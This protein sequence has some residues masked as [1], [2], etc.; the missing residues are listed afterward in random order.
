MTKTF[1]G[2]KWT[3][4]N[5][6]LNPESCIHG[7]RVLLQV[8]AQCVPWPSL[9]SMRLTTA[10]GPAPSATTSASTR[11]R[12][13]SS[14]A[15]WW[16]ARSASAPGPGSSSWGRGTRVSWCAEWRQPGPGPIS[17]GASRPLR[18]SGGS[19]TPVERW[20]QKERRIFQLNRGSNNT[21]ELQLI[22]PILILCWMD[23]ASLYEYSNR[24]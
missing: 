24:F 17:H 11:S 18:G 20:D 22:L 1:I 4:I 15:W 10:S 2:L 16:G 19:S 9:G 12:R 8:T 21:E 23:G 14:W 13:G 6:K 7:P 5:F 3:N